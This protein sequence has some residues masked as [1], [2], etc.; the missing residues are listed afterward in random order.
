MPQIILP[1][2]SFAG[3]FPKGNGNIG[4]LFHLHNKGEM[5]SITIRTHWRWMDLEPKDEDNVM[6]LEIQDLNCDLKYSL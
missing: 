2:S 3:N 5:Y 4:I 6:S 1:I